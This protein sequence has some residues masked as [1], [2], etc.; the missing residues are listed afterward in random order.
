MGAI[1]NLG[2]SVGHCHFRSSFQLMLPSLG[3]IDLQVHWGK[4]TSLCICGIKDA[5][6][7]S[8]LVP[9]TDAWATFTLIIV[10]SISRLE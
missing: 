1:G 8:A 5:V 2:A 7:H 10:I 6:F 9:T 4:K 3:L